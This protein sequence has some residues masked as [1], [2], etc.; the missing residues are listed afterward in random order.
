MELIEL[1][2]R[3]WYHVSG[4]SLDIKIPSSHNASTSQAA[5]ILQC[6]REYVVHMFSDVPRVIMLDSG[7]NSQEELNNGSKCSSKLSGLGMESF[8][9]SKVSNNIVY[10][11][12]K[13]LSI[14]N[15]QSDTIN[16]LVRGNT[17]WKSVVFNHLDDRCFVAWNKCSV[18]LWNRSSYEYHILQEC[19]NSNKSNAPQ[20]SAAN[21]SCCVLINYPD[22]VKISSCQFIGDLIIL[23]TSNG[24]YDTFS[25]NLSPGEY[26]RSIMSRQIIDSNSLLLDTAVYPNIRIRDPTINHMNV[27]ATL[28]SVEKD[29]YTVRI[30]NLPIDSNNNF[31]EI[32]LLQS[33]NIHIMDENKNS[34]FNAHIIGPNWGEYFAIQIFNQLIVCSVGE[35]LP[36]KGLFFFPSRLLETAAFRPPK[37]VTWLD[38]G[39]TKSSENLSKQPIE[40][41]VS[42]IFGGLESII[43]PPVLDLSANKAHYSSENISI[44]SDTFTINLSNQKKTNI[45]TNDEIADDYYA[46]LMANA[47]H[48]TEKSDFQYN[49][50]PQNKLPSDRSNLLT[51]IFTTLNME[52]KQSMSNPQ[53]KNTNTSN[54]NHKDSGLN[55]K[56]FEM[57]TDEFKKLT[58]S[59]SKELNDSVSSAISKYLEPIERDIQ[60]IK[61]HLSGIEKS[62]DNYV[63]INEI[64]KI[65]TNVKELLTSTNEKLTSI[66]TCISR[67]VGE[68]RSVREKVTK[69][70]KQCDNI[71]SNPI[72][73]FTQVVADSFGTL[74]NAVTQLQTTVNRLELQI[75]NG[76]PLK[77]LTP[78]NSITNKSA[79]NIALQIDDALKQKHYDRAFAIAISA[80]QSTLSQSDKREIPSGECFVLNL[81]YKFDP[82]VWLDD[83]LPISHPVILGISKILSDTLPHLIES[84]KTSGNFSQISCISDL[85]LRILWIKETIHC[86]EPFTDT[87]TPSDV[88]QILN[89][90][91]ESMN[92]CI[93]IINSVS[94]ASKSM[95]YIVPACF[96][97][98]SIISD[99]TSILRHI[100]RTTR[101]IT[102]GMK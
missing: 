75:S 100:R 4:S 8:S 98:G 65:E 68:S 52:E 11:K 60:S 80:D 90:I 76:I 62:V 69:L 71:N 57:I 24:Y 87:L 35:E 21:L 33:I 78:D 40:V 49:N 39:K 55:D 94:D 25:S 29:I 102:S 37:N 13:E 46:V 30:Y 17:H 89:E 28:L 5:S 82:C 16:T 32:T 12:G 48:K 92:K 67:L 56:I 70:N 7:I 58:F 47:S 61:S 45:D 10:I 72:D 1:P 34:Q 99:I 91:S 66:D 3:Q 81:A 14:V 51:S 43:I 54:T 15:I 50:T 22:D 26:Y 53:S 42:N 38:A 36:I 97:D 18:C 41:F 95:N 93:S 64:S 23:F 83:P 6:N 96:T 88:M 79:Q 27:T 9:L 84:L 2:K 20:H 31:G 86:F 73:N 74:T 101:N 77:A 19:S 44:P 63:N 85:K 59:L